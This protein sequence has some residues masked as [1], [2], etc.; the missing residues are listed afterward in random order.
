MT[1]RETGPFALVRTIRILRIP[2]GPKM[3][4]SGM[5]QATAFETLIEW[6]FADANVSFMRADHTR[7][8]CYA[9]RVSRDDRRCPRRR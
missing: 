1:A 7:R 5:V 6:F 3:L 8:G 9:C 4:D 2:S